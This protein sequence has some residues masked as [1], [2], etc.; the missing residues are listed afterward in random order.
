MRPA[1]RCYNANLPDLWSRRQALELS[2]RQ[3][4]TSSEPSARDVDLMTTHRSLNHEEEV[5]R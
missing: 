2:H 3:S 5:V 4:Q 1:K